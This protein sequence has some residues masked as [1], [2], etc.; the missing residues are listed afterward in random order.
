MDAII[1]P[2]LGAAP[3]L[4]GAGV[5][6]VILVLLMRREATDRAEY[7]QALEAAAKRH[8]EETD[9]QRKAHDAE[10]AELKAHVDRLEKKVA[11]LE[12]GRDQQVAQLQTRLD[13]EREARR[14]AEDMAAEA[15]RNPGSW[16]Q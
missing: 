3:Q 1:A 7:R 10:I 9:R 13:Q 4:G 5:L 14:R 16:A 15:R 8:D 11:E 12:A 2:L 6:L